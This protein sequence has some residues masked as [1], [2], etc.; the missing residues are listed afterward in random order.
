MPAAIIFD[1]LKELEYI[2]PVRFVKEHL[3]NNEKGVQQESTAKACKEELSDYLPLV[4]SRKH[5][6]RNICP[7]T[8]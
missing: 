5:F 6:A 7:R 8:E 2:E 1:K 4:H 3:K